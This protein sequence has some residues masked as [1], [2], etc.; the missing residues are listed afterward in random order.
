MPYQAG[1]HAAPPCPPPERTPTRER[2]DRVLSVLRQRRR[3]LTLALDNIHDPHNVSAILRSCDAFGL[4]EVHLHYTGEAFPLLN[5]R[6]SASAFKWVEQ[7]RHADAGRLAQELRDQGFALVAAGAGEQ[8]RLLPEWDFTRPTAVIL[9]N[10]Q[11][12]LHCEL[13]PHVEAWIMV[14]MLGMTPCLNVSVAASIILYEAWR[15]RRAAGLL[16]EPGLAA[17]EIEELAA[18]WLA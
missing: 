6:A 15:Q 18:S 12:G 16:D 13:A 2:R 3:D 8:A 10:E 14:P 17:G 5:K 7:R 9:G 11:R 4:A 1:M